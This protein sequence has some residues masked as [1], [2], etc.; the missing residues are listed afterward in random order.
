[1]RIR[2]LLTA[3]ALSAAPFA[4][5]AASN[6]PASAAAACVADTGDYDAVAASGG[7]Y[8]LGVPNNF[9]TGS[10]AELKPSQNSTTLLTHCNGTDA[11][12]DPV[13]AFT[14]KDSAGTVLALTTRDTSAG[15]TVT[16]EPLPAAGAFSS[17][18]WTYPS[19]GDPGLFT[20]RNVKTGLFLRVRNSGP[21]MYQTVTTGLHGS[22]WTQT[23]AALASIGH[24]IVGD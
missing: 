9:G 5:L 19:A 21:A 23:Q 12:G 15:G 17:Q 18:L 14:I 10:A 11:N 4:G 24:S 7:P 13:F 20:F 2:A 1:M 6:A 8:Y 3:A 16:L 22:A